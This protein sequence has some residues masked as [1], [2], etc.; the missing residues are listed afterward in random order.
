MDACLIYNIYNRI[1]LKAGI[2]GMIKILICCLGGFS[3]SAMVKKVKSEIIENN[4]QKEM[5]VD[6]SP[7]MNANKLYHEYDVI[8]V[9]PHTRYEVNGFVKKHYD[10]NIPI[11]VLPPKMYGLMKFDEIIQFLNS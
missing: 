5:S 2:I 8:M 3:S 7:F 10:L 4:L 1:I 6:F 11:Y 9:C